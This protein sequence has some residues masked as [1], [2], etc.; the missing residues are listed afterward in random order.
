M[1]TE[2][3]FDPARRYALHP[4]TALRPERFGALAYHYGNRRLTFLKSPQLSA[5]VESIGDHASV[6]AALHAH[7]VDAAN[8]PAMIAALARLEAAEVI[9]AA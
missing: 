3:S 9:R 5:V 4:Q 7:S 2:S 1:S 8:R 6:D